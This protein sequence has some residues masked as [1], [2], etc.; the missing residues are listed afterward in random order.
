MSWHPP[1]VVPID[2]TFR[3]LTI[4]VSNEGPHDTLAVRALESKI[5]PKWSWMWCSNYTLQ[6]C[7]VTMPG[8]SRRTSQGSTAR[9]YRSHWKA[10]PLE[11]HPPRMHLIASALPCRG[12]PKKRTREKQQVEATVKDKNWKAQS[13]WSGVGKRPRAKAPVLSLLVASKMKKRA[14]RPLVCALPSNDSKKSAVAFTWI[15]TY[16]L[17][18]MIEPLPSAQAYPDIGLSRWPD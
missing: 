4:P 14:K 8:S 10:G 16:M 5:A 13:D 12:V 11:T 2:Q 1:C 3:P 9:S 6:I 18:N 7:V 15:V 17:Q